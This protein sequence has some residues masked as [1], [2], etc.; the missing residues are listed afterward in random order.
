MSDLYRE[1]PQVAK[2]LE[3]AS[4][5]SFLSRFY[6]SEIKE[7]IDETLADLRTKIKNNEL[8]EIKYEEVVRLIV[9]KLNKKQIYSLRKV[10]NGTGTII[11]TNLG[12]S[13]LSEAAIKHVIEVCANYNNLEYNLVKGERGS[14][15]EHVEGMMAR[16]VGSEACLVVNN[17]AAAVLLSV[18]AFAKNKEVVVSRGELVEIGGSFR[19]PEI[20]ETSGAILREVGTTNRTHLSDYEKA[21]NDNTAIYLKVHPSNYQ[22]IGFTNNVTNDEIVSLAKK[23]NKERV[24]PIITIE[25]LGSGCLIDLSSS[26]YKENLVSESIKSGIDLVTF[27]GDKLLG[28]PQAGIIVGKKNLIDQLKK[29]PLLRAFRV[30]KMTIAALEGTIRDYFDEEKAKRTIPTLKMIYLSESELRERALMLYERIKCI[31]GISSEVISV[32]ST[33]GGG[34]LPHC[35]LASYGV[36]IKISN[37][38]AHEIE[39]VLRNQEVPIIGRIVNDKFLLDVR[40]L[41][42]SDIDIIINT[43][44]RI[45]RSLWKTS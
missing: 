31:E 30:D 34:S 18:S 5:K 41:L 7:V 10:I 33:I 42:D 20:I 8:K 25:D 29:H 1:I 28:G 17:N 26:G 14:R 37:Y 2:L 27:S 44:D 3:D 35:Q 22:I 24:K 4:I 40:T 13:L 11:H 39:R 21:T 16:L 12:R 38:P 32:Y 45:G 36:V 15:Y 6:I 19:I 43:L 9:E 23:M